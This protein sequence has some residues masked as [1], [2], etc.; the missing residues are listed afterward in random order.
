MILEEII[1]YEK[2]PNKR[3]TDG[4]LS[5]RAVSRA[6]IESIRLWRNAQMNVL[7]QVEEISPQ[8]QIE[9]FE[10]NIWSELKKNDPN[11]ILLAIEQNGQLI[12]YGGLVHISWVYKRA[13]L[14]FLLMP[15]LESDKIFLK[16]C[17][18]HF[19]KIMHQLAFEDLKLSR[20]TTETYANRVEHIHV[21]QNSG[22]R[23]EGIL[24]QHVVVN[25]KP[26][27]AIIHGFLSNE[28]QN[29]SAKKEKNILVTSASGKLPL[30]H[31]I[32]KAM[33]KTSADNILIAGDM[34]PLALSK[35][36]ADDFWHMPKLLE[37]NKEQLLSECLVR[38][39]SLII[40]TR[41]A[42]LE[43]WAFNRHFFESNGVNILV[44]SIEAVKICLDKLEFS[45]FGKRNNF[46]FIPSSLNPEFFQNVNLVVKE[47]FGSGS[48]NIGLNLNY[49]Q[50]LEHAKLLSNP[51][52][53]PYIHGNEISIDGWINKDGVVLGVVLRRR[54][55]VVNGE[56]QIT[57]TFRNIYFENQAIEILKTLGL[58]GPV[59]MQALIVDD[60]LH[61][62]ECN[63]R[64]GGASTASIAV[65]LDSF[66]WSLSEF[67]QS[68][69]QPFFN[70][71][72]IDVMQI[73]TSSDRIFYGS[74]F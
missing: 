17:F 65:G 12:G 47:R 54:D 51:I 63:P 41:D 68:S 22:H 74:N 52:F 11:Q 3:L 10:K 36:A 70:R 16:K 50:A 20:I 55:R 66:Y 21:L 19:L 14:S 26:M 2:M 57:T 62:I 34:D 44:S 31:A 6:D 38:K 5:L 29:S 35:F 49:K 72:E 42:E 40:P 64:F 61:I 43:Y 37:C 23:A 45:K 27:D 60:M 9:Y 56:S 13:E 39:I 46:T 8:K 18:E 32:K 25:N 71:L 24:R 1:E 69:E 67:N 33:N 30:I 59:V 15:E 48:R 73:R 4:W 53:Q 7:R 58:R 28:W